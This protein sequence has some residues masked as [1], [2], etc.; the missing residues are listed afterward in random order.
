METFH[1]ICI[2][3]WNI[4]DKVGNSFELKRGKEYLTSEEEKGFVMVFSSFWVQVPA[5]FFDGP[6][7]F[8]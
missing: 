2:R 6:K 8:T 5:E 1:R 7:G 3:D 4:V